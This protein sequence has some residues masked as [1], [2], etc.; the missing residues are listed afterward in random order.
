MR[1]HNCAI[2]I[3]TVRGRFWRRAEGGE[4]GE[5]GA[6]GGVGRQTGREKR[7]KQKHRQTEKEGETDRQTDR[8]T[9]K[10]RETYRRTWILLICNDVNGKV[11]RAITVRCRYIFKQFIHKNN[12]GKYSNM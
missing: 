1:A 4:G 5:E 9:E 3:S 8:Q 2:L 10:D 7:K 11:Y 12:F 6:E